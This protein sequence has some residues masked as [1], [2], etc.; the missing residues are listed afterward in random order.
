MKIIENR[1]IRVMLTD[2]QYL[3]FFTA[4]KTQYLP[5]GDTRQTTSK[6]ETRAAILSHAMR[7]L[8]HRQTLPRLIKDGPDIAEAE[9]AVYNALVTEYIADRTSYDAREIG[10]WLNGGN[11]LSAGQREALAD[12]RAHADGLFGR[13]SRDEIIKRARALIDD[14]V[15]DT[16]R[17]WRRLSMMSGE[18]A[19]S[20]I[21]DQIA[22][23]AALT[24]DID[25]GYSASLTMEDYR[26]DVLDPGAM[27]DQVG[28]Q[29]KLKWV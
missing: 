19:D 11:I 28:F 3:K 24:H 7:A 27:P 16:D 17:R 4:G 10:R 6:Q 8:A 9:A 18:N 14:G 13:I 29:S 22:Q 23:V 12:A 2:E 1:K 20:S 5:S 25:V 15:R 21:P 26:I